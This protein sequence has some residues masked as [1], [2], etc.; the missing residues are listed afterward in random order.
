[1]N[2]RADNGWSCSRREFAAGG[3]VGGLLLLAGC[4][5][6]ALSE[7]LPGPV[8]PAPEVPVPTM[9]PPVAAGPSRAPASGAVAGDVAIVPRSSWTRSGV[10][11]PGEINPMGRVT[12]ITIHHDGIDAFSS[13]DA[14]AC[15][16]RIEQIRQSHVSGRR[17]ADIGY[18]YI[19]DPAG[20]VWE[21]R[22]V[23]FQGAHV[24]DNNEQNLGILCLGNFDV[25]AP[26]SA[27][28]QALDRLV[29]QQMRRYRVP[30]GRVYTHQ[31]IRPTACPGRNLQR[32]MVATRSG[33]GALRL[34]IA[35]TLPDLA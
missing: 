5:N 33:S 28:T 8:P 20:R 26:S 16:R 32:Y 19:V 3:L 24:Q 29:V 15:A 17:W 34:A 23:R 22:N 9:P 10:A 27:Q 7:P 11:R 2:E 21:G 1:M 12:R 14:N 13:Q 18:H 25:Q 31:E 30:I 4:Q 35:G 6:K